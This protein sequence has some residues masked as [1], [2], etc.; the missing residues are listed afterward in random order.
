[1]PRDLGRDR[2]LS[3]IATQNE[4]AATALELEQ[5]MTIVAE[6]ARVLSGAEAAVVELVDGD[7]M[8]YRVGRGAAE[9]YEG[10]RLDIASS[11]SG[12]SVLERRTLH[13]RDAREDDRVDLEAAQRVGA[14]SMICVPLTHR[15]RVVGVLKIYDSRPNAF[16]DEDAETLDL[17][18]GVIGAHMSHASD[19]A[20]HR[21]DSAH[22]AL[23]G[24]PNRRTFD[25]R[26]PTEI[27]R[28]QRLGTRLSLCL[29]DLDGFKRVNDTRGHAAGDQVLKAV[30]RHLQS[31]RAGDEAFRYG[32]DE[33]ALL[34][35]GASAEGAESVRDRIDGVIGADPACGGVG[36]SWGI[37]ELTSEDDSV[38]LFARADSALYEAKRGLAAAR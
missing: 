18:S 22:D 5:V 4:I 29:I 17:L 37:E 27:D 14:L 9:Q 36:A 6:R 12:Q 25:R 21:H 35:I 2:L 16:S 19:F 34:L 8:V 31:L 15:G 7:E 3:I 23:T 24:L 10:L 28:A 38:G 1:M 33:F 13:C 32:G 11:L 30:A 26:L 20:E